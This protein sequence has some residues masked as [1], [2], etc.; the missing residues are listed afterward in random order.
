MV[1]KR[2]LI[3]NFQF[4]NNEDVGEGNIDADILVVYNNDCL[5][6]LKKITK[7]LGVEQDC[8]YVKYPSSTRLLYEF[9]R[10]FKPKVIIMACDKNQSA[11]EF[12]KTI[13][14]VDTKLVYTYCPT[15]MTDKE[16]KQKSKEHW[17][18]AIKEIRS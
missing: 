17:N 3:D 15:E 12:D 9:S 4:R 18:Q 1:P 10:L 13:P 14:L 7:Y 5:P 2:F 16:I 6:Q 8:W 11:R